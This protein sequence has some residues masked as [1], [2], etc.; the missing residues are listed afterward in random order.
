MTSLFGSPNA[1]QITYG[2]PNGPLGRV[3]GRWRRCGSRRRKA[4]YPLIAIVPQ[5]VT[6]QLPAG[7]AVATQGGVVEYNT[8][9]VT[10]RQYD[11]HVAVALDQNARRL[12]LTAA[13]VVGCDGAHS[14]VRHHLNLPFDGA[15]YDGLFMLADI[16]TNDTLQ[17]DQ[18][19]L[20]PSEF[21]PA[22]LFPMSATRR[23]LVATIRECGRRTRRH[24]RWCSRFSVDADQREWRRQRCIGA[25][26]TSRI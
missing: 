14:T 23:H 9:F 21:G 4:P 19:Q 16:Q 3:A 11:D 10:A 2:P 18:L 13:F 1:P 15:A 7:R 25:A 6:E 12:E 20:C 8:A 5:N 22:A 26:W 24:S 17:A